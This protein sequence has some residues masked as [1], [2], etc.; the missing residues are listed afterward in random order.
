MTE[1]TMEPK[2]GSKGLIIG[3]IV[4]LVLLAGAAFVG[5]RLLNQA[6]TDRTTA[7]GSDPAMPGLPPGG[8]FNVEEGEGASLNDGEAVDIQITP[9]PELPAREPD[10]RG[11]YVNRE[12]DTITIGTGKVTTFAAEG[13]APEYNYEGLAVEVLVTNQTALY[14]DTTQFTPGQAAPMQQTVRP[15]DNLDDL[16]E[17][18]NLQVWGRREGDRIVAE[19]IVLTR[20]QAQF[21]P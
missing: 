21:G 11:L 9:A 4:L 19:T 6:K 10:A 1:E 3:G 5:G 14:E 7:A 13:E 16:D 8:A 20:P 17:G 15:L 12:D 2:R 18:T